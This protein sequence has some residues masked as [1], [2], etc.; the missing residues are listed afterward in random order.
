[1]K[2][3]AIKRIAALVLAVVM[4]VGSVQIGGVLSV[5]AQESDF[6]YALVNGTATITSYT[7]SAT[8]LVIPEKLDGY[9]VTELRREA[10]SDCSSLV[11][12]TI[13][14][15][16]TY[17][18]NQCFHK[19]PNLKNIKVD[20]NSYYYKDI[21]GILFTRDGSIL[22][23]YPSAK[24]DVG[25]VVP[26]SVDMIAIGSFQDCIYLEEVIIT[27]NVLYVTDYAFANCTSLKAVWLGLYALGINEYAFYG[28]SSLQYVYISS[29][30]NMMCI[31][32]YAFDGCDALETVIFFDTK[33]RWAEVSIGKNNF[34]PSIMFYVYCTSADGYHRYT[35][36]ATFPTT[37]TYGYTTFTCTT[38]GSR[39]IEPYTFPDVQNTQWYYE[40]VEFAVAHRYFTGYESGMFGPAD[41][42]TRQDFVLVLARIDGAD[43][44]QYKYKSG[45]NDVA[46]GSY[47][48]AAVN[49][50]SS[51]GIVTGYNPSDFGVGDKITREQLV[52]MLYRYARKKGYDVTVSPEAA[53]KPEQYTDS[54]KIS[55]F[56]QEAVVWALDRGVIKGLNET[57][58]GPQG[59]ASRAQAAQILKNIH[60]NGVLPF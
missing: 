49:W 34:D 9:T 59:F 51:N 52:T 40:A 58:I 23:R 41:N 25:Y 35:S 18:D 27:D 30:I 19:C 12:V 47:Y 4:L 6:S 39:Y 56:A 57:Q 28:C 22:V 15:T 29:V 8:D 16:V 24:T 13:P 32:D 33:T 3:Y 37:S 45:F 50:A 21:D 44:A 60:D 5:A 17:V 48:E 26:E 2:R 14:K 11:N 42:I 1:M 54:E 31:E 10:F 36:K 53:T 43:L 20:K 7:G 46:R 38:C 55:T